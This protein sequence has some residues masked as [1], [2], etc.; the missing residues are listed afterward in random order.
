MQNLLD[1]IKSKKKAMPAPEQAETLRRIGTAGATGKAVGP[2][3]G[4]AMSNIAAQRAA[5]AGQAQMEQVELAQTAGQQ[6]LGFAQQMGERQVQSAEDAQRQQ[7]LQQQ[8]QLQTQQIIQDQRRAT[9]ADMAAEAML[10]QEQ[11]LSKQLESSYANILSKL[12]TDRGIAEQD[13]FQY[14]KQARAELGA[15][16]YR[17]FLE[18]TAHAMALSDKKYTDTLRRIGQKRDLQNQI[19][20]KREAMQLA[21]GQDFEILGQQFNMQRLMGADAR[22]F[23]TQLAKMDMN[24]AIQLAEQASKEAAYKSMITGATNIATG[25]VAYNSPTSSNNNLY[26]NSS[27][28]ATGQTGL[29]TGGSNLVYQ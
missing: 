14:A 17:A 3:T 20:F 1:I 5:Q 27:G 25:I 12:A 10:A 26:V 16:R 11:N 29:G 6:Q 2:Q 8:R 19:N 23:K 13:I 24:T 7:F 9:Q 22:E 4:P 18:Q 28:T 15:E 21:M